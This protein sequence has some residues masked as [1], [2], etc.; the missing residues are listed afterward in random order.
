MAVLY[1]HTQPPATYLRRR[2]SASEN[3][4]LRPFYAGTCE[5]VLF[6]H[7]L[8]GTLLPFSGEIATGEMIAVKA[9]VGS[10]VGAIEDGEGEARK[11]S[12]I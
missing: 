4:E 12:D 6:T 10:A 11:A 3:V 7:E 5:G 9:L 8:V 2:K 1:T